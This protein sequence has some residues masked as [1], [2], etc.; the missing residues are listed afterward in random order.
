MNHLNNT[1]P[2]FFRRVFVI[3]IYACESHM[4][5][6]TPNNR[7]S[8]TLLIL[9]VFARTNSDFIIIVK[10]SGYNYSPDIVRFLLDKWCHYKRIPLY[11]I[12]NAVQHDYGFSWVDHTVVGKQGTVFFGCSLE[13][14]LLN[15]SSRGRP[16]QK[17]VNI[18]RL[19]R[20][21]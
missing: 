15:F 14:L 2:A 17:S 7:V 11:R 21:Q 19:R 9:T 12:T 10:D 13:T 5:I 20:S 16:I 4:A 18:V 6:V 3:M 1:R 8:N